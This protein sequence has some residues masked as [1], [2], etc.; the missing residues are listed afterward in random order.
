[1]RSGVWPSFTAGERGGS[2][3]PLGPASRPLAARAESL[4]LRFSVKL[5]A[6]VLPE[7]RELFKDGPTGGLSLRMKPY[8]SVAMR[9]V[10]DRRASSFST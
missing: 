7:F 2:P 8:R 4:L 10:P 6:E 9:G 1:M 3:L 5:S